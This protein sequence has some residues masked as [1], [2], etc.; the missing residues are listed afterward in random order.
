[1]KTF[2]LFLLGSLSASA[3]LIS[4]GVKGGVPLT[5][6]FETVSNPTASFSSP[7]K[8]Y[9]VGPSIEVNLPAGLGIEFDALYRR[10]NFSS[11]QNLVDSIRAAT[12]TANAWEF[13]LLLKYKAG[14]GPARPFVDGGLSFNHISGVTQTVE[15]IIFP[16]R[17]TT[18][19]SSGAPELKNNLS[20]GFVLGAGIDVHALFLHLT[21]EIRY[22]R[23]GRENFNGL[24]GLLRSNQNQAEFL[25][26]VRF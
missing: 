15:N 9:I 10:M 8:R 7:T 21:P 3:Q 26:G 18:T 13:P 24:N 11:T 5:D 12:T 19:S 1:M 14:H 4:A 23:W 2:L 22:T 16:G 25:L 17:R 20:P 6:F